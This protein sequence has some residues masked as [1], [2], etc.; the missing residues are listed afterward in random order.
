MGAPVVEESVK[1]TKKNKLPQQRVQF[2]GKTILVSEDDDAEMALLKFVASGRHDI[3]EKNDPETAAMLT[4]RFIA[5]KE[6]QK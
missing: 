5:I 4:K 1:P 6:R 3:L 2:F